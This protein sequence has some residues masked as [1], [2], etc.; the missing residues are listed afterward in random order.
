MKY[1]ISYIWAIIWGAI[2]C[3]LLLLPSNN[4]NKVSVPLFDGIDKIVHLGIFFI[5]ATLLYWEAARKSQYKAN[6]WITILKV[7]ITTAIFA[8]LTEV[9]QMY[10][11]NTRT[12]DPWDVLADVT[13]VGMATFAFLLIYKRE[14]R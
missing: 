9:A 7:I 2:I 4:F 5:Q 6:Q 10:L 12:E 3:V 11:T 14:K 8:V 1:L 13:G